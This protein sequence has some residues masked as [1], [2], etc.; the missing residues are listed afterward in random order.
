MSGPW[1]GKT[2]SWG[3]NRFWISGPDGEKNPTKLGRNGFSIHGGTEPGSAG[4]ID[5]TKFMAD[6]TAYFKQ[7]GKNLPLIVSYSED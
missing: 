5:A 6:F 7:T 4:C 2:N 3:E 1:P